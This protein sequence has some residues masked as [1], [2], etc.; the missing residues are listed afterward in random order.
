MQR[1]LHHNRR[2]I[3]SVLAACGMLG[4]PAMAVQPSGGG[5]GG[6]SQ[7]RR[8]AETARRA[9][10]EAAAEAIAKAEAARRRATE[11]QELHRMQITDAWGSPIE[12]VFSSRQEPSDRPLIGVVL[13]EP[14]P[15]LLE[16][17]GLQQGRTVLIQQVMPDTPAEKAGMRAN[18]I[19]V[20]IDGK[21]I[22]GVE[23]FRTSIGEWEGEGPIVF[24]VIRRGQEQEISVTPA[25]RDTNLRGRIIETQIRVNP[26]AAIREVTERLRK[27]LE[28]NTAVEI[29]VEVEEAIKKLDSVTK[30]L[31]A[32][33]PRRLEE[34]GVELNRYRA[35][36][37]ETG[38]YKRFELPANL[39]REVPAGRLRELRREDL[40]RLRATPDGSGVVEEIE[41]RESRVSPQAER[42][43]TLEASVRRLEN[44]L[45][46]L[47]EKLSDR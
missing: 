7:A 30:H 15:V 46:Q 8:E 43:D 40:P 10:Q 38:E 41:V 36:D 39:Y 24:R 1:H 5:A 6:G 31:S 32:L 21:D 26:D 3:L 11:V 19:V 23:Q 34:A 25:P 14:D 9:A 20:A 33:Q 13:S 35:V 28:T 27:A 42:L 4:V 22:D 47:L 44:K 2:R 29:R 17:L 45:D 37:P 18:D 12:L 16:H